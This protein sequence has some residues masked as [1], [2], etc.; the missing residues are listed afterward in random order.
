M[1]HFIPSAF[2]LFFLSACLPVVSAQNPGCDGSRY[3]DNKFISVKKSTVN[4]ATATVQ[5]GDQVTLAMD[6]YEPEGDNITAR[7]V[8]V[9]AHGGSFIIGGKGDM[10]PWCQLLAKKGYVAVSIQYRLFPFFQLGLP[11]SVDIFDQAVRAVG[12]MKAAVR[13]FREDAATVNQFR[14]DADNIF[15]GGFSAGAV[16]ALHAGYLDS[17][18]AIPAFIQTAL[19]A[20]GGFEGSSGSASNKTYSSSIKAV[21]NM[22]GGLYRSDWVAGNGIPLVSIH[23]TA[24]E[25]VPYISGLAANLAYLEGSGLI[26]QKTEAQGLLHNLHTV[27]GGGHTNIYEPSQTTYVP[28]IDTFW[29]NATTMLE[30]LVCQTVSTH[31]AVLL[32]EDWI[33]YP[34]PATDGTFHI[35]LPEDVQHA[36]VQLADVAGKIVFQGQNIQNQ[37]IVRPGKLPAGIYA[38]R[39]IDAGDSRRQFFTKKL[40]LGL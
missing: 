32:P 39:I 28:H 34:N 21:V 11:D 31:D 8:V 10:Q 40:V 2:F 6:V 37:S 33:L 23:G 17:T 22:S 27:P 12:D 7:P 18:D 3:K 5:S 36:I 19:N 38:V 1:K 29:T 16:T 20:N 30:Y 26:H 4:Y 15:I 25:T 14:A 13:Y 9:L 24:D 35:Q